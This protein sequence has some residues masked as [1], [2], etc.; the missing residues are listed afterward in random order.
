MFFKSLFSKKKVKEEVSIPLNDVEKWMLE[1][2]KE[3]IGNVEREIRDHYDKIEKDIRAIEESLKEFEVSEMDQNAPERI[4]IMAKT[5]KSLFEEN[6]KRFIDSVNIPKEYDF[7]TAQKFCRELISKIN[8]LGKKSVKITGLLKIAIGESMVDLMKKIDE[9]EEDVTNMQNFLI[10]KEKTFEEIKEI[11]HLVGDSRSKKSKVTE[12]DKAIERLVDELR[13]REEKLRDIQRKIDEF[14]ESTEMKRHEE[15]K[16]ELDT[17][18]SKRKTIENKILTDISHLEKIFKKMEHY[19]EGRIKKML[20]KYIEFPLGVIDNG[21][22]DLM[23][24]IKIAEEEIKR[25]NFSEKIIKKAK[26]GIDNVK[27]GKLDD[28]IS[29][30]KKLSSKIDWLLKEMNSMEVEKK[31]RTIEKDLEKA[32]S[33]KTSLEERIKKLKEDKSSLKDEIDDQIEEIEN[34]LKSITDKKVYI[35]K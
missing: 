23:E 14:N 30:H 12:I 26:I 6:L 33:E 28:L 32:V 29:E 3:F 35:T 4:R 8:D 24:L 20:K 18:K 31:K 7:Y 1:E 5:S 10:G 22:K 17:L 19:L 25:K 11:K 9:L 21:T 34:K 16:K 13:I 27:S 15:I 2:K